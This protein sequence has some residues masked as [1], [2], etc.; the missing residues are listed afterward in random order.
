[1][2]ARRALAA[3]AAVGLSGAVSAAPMY[4]VEQLVVNVMSA[5]E[6]GERIAILK[7]GEQVEFL[8]KSGELAHV[9]LTSGKDG[10]VRASYLMSAEPLRLQLSQRDGEVAQLKQQLADLEE[11]L[12][13]ATAAAPTPARAAPTAASAAD[14]P[15]TTPPLF[16]TGEGGRAVRRW[17]WTLAA[18]LAGLGLGFALGALLLDRHIRRKYGGLRIY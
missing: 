13:S 16:S 9:R 8:E 7:S 14:V 18:G 17:P 10:W 1:V 5:P 2:G 6:G 11:R 3:L 12:R 4:V 15:G